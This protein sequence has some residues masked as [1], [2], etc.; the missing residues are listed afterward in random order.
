M[1]D[2][3][4]QRERRNLAD[5]QHALDL[6]RQFEET[7]N[8]LYAWDAIGLCLTADLEFPPT[9][10]TYLKRV[11]RQI[12]ALTRFEK[13]P[14]KGQINKAIA[15]AIGIQ[16]SGASNPFRDRLRPG[17]DILLAFEVYQFQT[18]HRHQNYNWT[19]IF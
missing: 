6:G 9:I 3:E 19:G 18:D 10:R 15:K 12:T 8:V 14:T 7:N 17:H 1:P 16:R 2:R 4:A 13:V 11:A 5:Q